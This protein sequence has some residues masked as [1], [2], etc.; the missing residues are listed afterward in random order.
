VLLH[1]GILHGYY[2]EAHPFLVPPARAFRLIPL[3]Y[4]SFLIIAALLA[5][6]ARRL[7]VTGARAGAR[8]GLLLGGALWASMVAGLASITTAPLP[9]LLGWLVGQPL[10]V[11]LAGGVIGAAHAGMRRTKLWALVAAW[12]VVALAITVVLQNVA[13]LRGEAGP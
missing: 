12:C 1:G 9:L 10:E 2:L 6:L 4:L 7:D 11:A 5:W 8:F 13:V 3:G